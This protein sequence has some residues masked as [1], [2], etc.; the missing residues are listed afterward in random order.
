MRPIGRLTDGPSGKVLWGLVL[1]VLALH[2]ALLTGVTAPLEVRLS[3]APQASV[4]QVRVVQPAPPAPPKRPVARPVARRAAP[5]PVPTA[6]PAPS[7]N[8]PAACS[9]SMATATTS[10]AAATLSAPISS[11]PH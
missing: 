1:L 2:T 8:A 9:A 4:V 11:A 5:A 7:A 3:S 6:L 10:Q